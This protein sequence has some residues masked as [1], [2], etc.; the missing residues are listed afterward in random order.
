MGTDPLVAGLVLAAG[1]GTRFGGR[2]QLA[3]LDGRPQLEHA[4]AAMASAPV[5]PVAV[6]LGADSDEIAAAVDMHGAEPIV[7]PDWEEGQSA[8]LRTG[9]DALQGAGAD[10]VVV[11]LGDQP[12]IATRA[13]AAVVA[14]RAGAEAD[15]VR[16][17]Y[18]GTP[19]HP[20]L[21]ESRLFDAVRLLRGDTGAREV[22]RTARVIDV[23]CDGLGDPADVD[24]PDDLNA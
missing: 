12:H 16:A 19:G 21:L 22:L 14:A 2:K 11:T 3:E 4:L 24:T 10:A 9:I 23:P 17:T 8:S 1:A 20:V 5:Q 6:V 18:H 13:I 7:C 15:A